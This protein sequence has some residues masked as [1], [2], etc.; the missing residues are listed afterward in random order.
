MALIA[1]GIGLREYK[2]WWL[3]QEL[4]YILLASKILFYY[5]ILGIAQ[6][7]PVQRTFST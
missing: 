1:L 2:G 3:L 5:V 7:F 4:K 6:W